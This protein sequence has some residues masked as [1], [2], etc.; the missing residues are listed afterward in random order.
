MVHHSVRTGLEQGR[1]LPHGAIFPR[2]N[3]PRV[4]FKADDGTLGRQ[5]RVRRQV[6]RDATATAA[7]HG[8]MRPSPVCEPAMMWCAASAYTHCQTCRQLI[9]ANQSLRGCADQ[10]T[11]TRA[12]SGRLRSILDGHDEAERTGSEDGTL[13]RTVYLR[14]YRLRACS[15][16]RFQQASFSSGVPRAEGTTQCLTELRHVAIER[17]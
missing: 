12:R 5:T 17:A 8:P 15:L 6:R 7:G 4:A 16:R 11:L 10:A 1:G 13:N 3:R 2:S 9:A 14:P